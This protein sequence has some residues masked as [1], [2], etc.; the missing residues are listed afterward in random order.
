MTNNNSN[1]VVSML[2]PYIITPITKFINYQIH[3]KFPLP[4]SHYNNVTNLS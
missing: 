4:I 3:F 2:L 1:M